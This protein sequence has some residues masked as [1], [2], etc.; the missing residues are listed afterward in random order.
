MRQRRGHGHAGPGLAGVSAREAAGA[1]SRGRAAPEAP[2][3]VRAAAP[4]AGR[5]QAGKP[6]AGGPS[7]THGPEECPPGDSDVRALGRVG[8][9]QN[10]AVLT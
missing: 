8:P 6:V 4:P 1:G 5:G 3:A 2:G 10:T 7:Q 9:D